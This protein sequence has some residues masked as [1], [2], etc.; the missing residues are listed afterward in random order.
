MHRHIQPSAPRHPLLASVTAHIFGLLDVA[1]TIWDEGAWHDV[2]ERATAD[3][4]IAFEAEHGVE[5]ERAAYNKRSLERARNTGRT[6]VATHMGLTDLFVPVP[7]PMRVDSVLVIGPVAKA[8]PS[9]EE[10]RTRW[11]VLTGRTGHRTDPEFAH[12]VE[13]TLRVLTLD[14][15][16][17]KSFQRLAECLA[18]LVGQQ[19][20]ARRIY[21]S[22]V[23][24]LRIEL[25]APRRADRMWEVARAIV[26][27]RTSRSWASPARAARLAVAGLPRFPDQVIA[28][29]FVD[30]KKQGDDVSAILRRDGFLRACADLAHRTGGVASGRLGTHG[31]TFL[32]A[33]RGSA[34]RTHAFLLDLASKASAIAQRRFGLDL[35]VGLG[36]MTGNLPDQFRSALMAAETALSRDL[37]SSSIDAASPQIPPDPLWVNLPMLLG[38]RPHALP[39]HF[40]RYLE[41]V[42]R[43]SRYRLDHA[44]PYLAG[45]FE[46]FATAVTTTEAI[47][48]R[49]LS[50]L[51]K[52][53][54]KKAEEATTLNEL[55]DA[56][57]AAV[58]AISEGLAEPRAA[59]HSRSLRIAEE[60]IERHHA[61]PFSIERVA[62]A[63]GLGRSLFSRL[64]RERHGVTFQTYVMRQRVEHSRQLLSSTSLGLQRVA[65]LSGL[66]SRFYLGRVFKRVT[67]E[68]PIAYR[69]RV[70]A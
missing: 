17:F 50:L 1:V 42:A 32:A 63:C 46:P 40:D 15:S 53:L 24:A 2:H 39:A 47:G 65:Q 38:R 9:A 62:R 29:L 4:I 52:V 64:F 66:S 14:G 26:D 8:R 16:L 70:G 35:H 28:G 44:R 27:E 57:R 21:D 25:A 7:G 3:E 48:G 68:T 58:L 49:N 22:D 45:A 61:E 69:R 59:A 6:V 31:V 23:E 67:G 10:L 33:S 34:Q 51:R 18:L 12:Y 60:F 11:T 13:S 37:R 20:D 56:Y 54:S 19:D 43:E 30:R 41:S 36:P 5:F 55:F